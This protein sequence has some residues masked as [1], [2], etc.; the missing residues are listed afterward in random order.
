M[1][2]AAGLGLL[3]TAL[4]PVPP[5][6]GRHRLTGSS[7]LE[8]AADGR[9]RVAVAPGASGLD[10]L[11][12]LWRLGV[13]RVDEVSGPPGARAVVAVAEQFGAD[14]STPRAEGVG[15]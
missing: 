15:E 2:V 1:V 3:A 12:A 6:P 7:V 4:V 9:R 14:F 8:V 11:D 13:V 10:V 5:S